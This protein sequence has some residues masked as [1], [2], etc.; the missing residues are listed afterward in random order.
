[1]SATGRGE[2]GGGGV[3]F[4]GTPAWTVDWLLRAVDLPSGNW[5]EPSAGEG[6]IVRA[7]NARRPDVTQWTVVELREECRRSLQSATAE[8]RLPSAVMC[9]VDWCAPGWPFTV[10]QIMWPVA[11]GNPPYAEAE[12]HVAKAIQCAGVVAF[13]LRLH[14]L[15]SQKRAEFWRRHPADVYVLSERPSFDGEG[16]DATEYAWFVWGQCGDGPGRIR[17]LG[18]DANQLPLLAGV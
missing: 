8:T 3:D 4:F 12:R 6:A 11:I 7:V 15:G 18:P 1:M 16:T 17:V 14:F 5:L 10:P 9:G 13:L 2:R